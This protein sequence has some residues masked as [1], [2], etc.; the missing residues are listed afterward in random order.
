MI[1]TLFI[2]GSGSFIG[3]VS[4][5]LT[6]RFIQNSVISSFPFGTFIVNILGCF[7][8]GFFYGLSERGN[9]INNEWRMF[10]TI[11]FCG[12]FTTFSTF[13]S[14]NVSLLRDGNFFY[15]AIYAS[16][17]LFLGLTATYLG[18]LITKI[19]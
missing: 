19:F 18:N 9:L 1:K 2:I 16:L 8:V 7:L 14:E 10:L 15:F 12:G 17:S 11:G 3:G 5:Y 6:S 4:R 13:S